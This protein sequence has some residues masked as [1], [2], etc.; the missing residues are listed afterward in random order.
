LSILPNVIDLSVSYRKPNSAGVWHV[1]SRWH[2]EDWHAIEAARLGTDH[3]T[4]KS[5]VGPGN[6][7]RS[8]SYYESNEKYDNQMKT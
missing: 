7:N 1:Q 3:D 2:C 4:S 5:Q 6:E 8:I